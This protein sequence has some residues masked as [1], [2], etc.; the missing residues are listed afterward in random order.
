MQRRVLLLG[1]QC[2]IQ[3][4]H[5]TTVW[6]SGWCMGAVRSHIALICTGHGL[7]SGNLEHCTARDDS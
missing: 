2:S 1:R 3:C 7:A 4:L 6:L 5:V